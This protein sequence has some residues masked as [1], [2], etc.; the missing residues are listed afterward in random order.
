MSSSTSDYTYDF[1]GRLLSETRTLKYSDGVTITKTFAF[2]YEESEIVGVIFT[3]PNGTATYYY[4]KNPRGDVVGILDNT[5]NAVVKYAYDAFGNCTCLYSAN[6]DLAE[7]NPIRYRSYYFDADTGLY[8]L[9][10]RY[11]SPEWRRFI[12]PDDTAYLD[13]ETVNGLNLYAYCGNDPVNYYDP[14]GHSALL[15]VMGILAAAGLITTSVGVATDNNIVTAIGLTMVTVPALISGASALFSGATYLSIIGG[16]AAFAG[17]GT[18]IFASAEYQEAFTGNNWILNAGCSE[19]WYNGLML[20]TTVL[21]TAGTITSGVLS[22]IGNAT[23]Y[24]QM[25]TSFQNN[26]SRWKVVKELIE[27]SNTYKGGISTYSNYINKWT[28]SNF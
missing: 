11:Y 22:S 6:G 3:N 19:E 16:T 27:S 2:L 7:S 10:A 12:S 28:G 9:H 23:T 14:S 21:A 8:Y 17:V 13:I 5:G 20:T 18:A 24:S 4:D 26:P 15:I 1:Q 25:M